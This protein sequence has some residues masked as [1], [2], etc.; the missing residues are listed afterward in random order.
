MIPK[1]RIV[2]GPRYDKSYRQYI[3]MAKK[4]AL[5]ERYDYVVYNDEPGSVAY[6]PS[7]SFGLFDG[8]VFDNVIA[9]IR[10]IGL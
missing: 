2:E 9:I 3:A 1:A 7:C 5:R 10:Y 8:Q 4:D 6:C